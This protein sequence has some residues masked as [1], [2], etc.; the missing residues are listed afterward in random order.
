MRKVRT[1]T[2]NGYFEIPAS[3][4][5]DTDIRV[6]REEAGNNPN[7]DENESQDY[8]ELITG[9]D[10]RRYAIY[11]INDTDANLSNVDVEGSHIWDDDWED[12]QVVRNESNPGGGGEVL[13][14]RSAID[15]L[16]V[17]VTFDATPSSGN[18]KVVIRS[19]E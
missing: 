18:L 5:G 13:T 9:E 11:V 6:P 8:Y 15:R 12:A 3:E 1:V 16:N 19:A 17:K 7:G 14:N 2:N 10:S 4:I